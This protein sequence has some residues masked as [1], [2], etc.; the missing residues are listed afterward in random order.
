MKNYFYLDIFSDHLDWKK[1]KNST[2]NFRARVFS[3]M[4]KIS[5]YFIIEPSW[6]KF[7]SVKFIYKIKFQVQKGISRKKYQVIYCNFEK[8][9]RLF[10]RLP[11]FFWDKY[12]KPQINYLLLEASR[13]IFLK[14][15]SRKENAVKNGKEG[16]GKKERNQE[17]N[18]NQ[19]FIKQENEFVN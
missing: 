9:F 19:R 12:S 18:S 1:S 10:Q 5:K 8:S 7:T 15:C 16:N 13:T 11:W 2:W 4:N 6:F 14:I 3:A 17:N